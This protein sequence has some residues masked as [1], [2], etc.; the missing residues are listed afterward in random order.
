MKHS[1][2]TMCMHLFRYLCEMNGYTVIDSCSKKEKDTKYA[3]VGKSHSASQNDPYGIQYIMTYR[4]VRDSSISNIFRFY[5]DKNHTDAKDVAHLYGVRI[6]LRSMIENIRLY[7]DGITY[8]PIFFCYEDYQADPLRYI[9]FVQAMLFKN[10]LKIEQA[11][12]ILEKLVKDYTSSNLTT[13]LKTYYEEKK[14]NSHAQ[15][16]M[17]D[18]NTANGKIGKYETFFSEKQNQ[19]ILQN[20]IIKSWLIEN[21]YPIVASSSGGNGSFIP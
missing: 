4:D 21:D 3:I 13:N 9:F 19:L 18:H 10:H 15:L 6:F 5:F 2:S 12:T 7:Y 8:C 14:K 11:Q 1:G 16:L 20:R 17:K